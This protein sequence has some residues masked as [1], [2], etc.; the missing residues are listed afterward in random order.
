MSTKLLSFTSKKR[1]TLY[2]I[3]MFSILIQLQF[4]DSNLTA[5]NIIYQWVFLSLMYLSV[6]C[7][8]PA[9]DRVISQ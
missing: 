5:Q 6:Y 9:E 4:E 3:A 1:M 2:L 8:A 7:D